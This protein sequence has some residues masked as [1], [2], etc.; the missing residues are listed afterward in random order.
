MKTAAE[1]LEKAAGLVG[2]DRAATHGDKVQNHQNIARLWT[3]YLQNQGSSVLSAE[4]VACM[5]VLLKI[6]RTQL[7]DFNPDDYVDAA[8]YAAIG[9][10]IESQF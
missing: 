6:A 1:M 10:E 4:D 5:M 3:A 9:F 2:G 7:G 8:G